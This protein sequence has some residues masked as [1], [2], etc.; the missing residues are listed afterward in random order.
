M[1]TYKQKPQETSWQD[2]L[3]PT[4]DQKSSI[5]GQARIGFIRKV[6][7][8]VFIQLLFSAMFSAFTMS[9]IH[10]RRFVIHHDYVAIACL[11]GALVTMLILLFS[12]RMAK[13]VRFL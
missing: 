12:E 9:N 8:I 7:S 10:A 6:F 3:S 5:L 4:I 1:N 2:L 11:I 13:S